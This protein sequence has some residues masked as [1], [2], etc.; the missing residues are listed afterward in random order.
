MEETDDQEIVVTATRLNNDSGDTSGR[1]F[2]Y[3]EPIIFPVE[4]GVASVLRTD[5]EEAIT[6]RRT[7]TIETKDG[8]VKISVD[9]TNMSDAQVG[10]TVKLLQEHARSP[11]AKAAFEVIARADA[12]RPGGLTITFRYDDKFSLYN[13]DT[14]SFNL[15]SFPSDQ[16]GQASG[17]RNASGNYE[18]HLSINSNLARS[19]QDFSFTAAHELF[20]VARDFGGMAGQFDDEELAADS[21]ANKVLD[22][23]FRNNGGFVNDTQ[24]YLHQIIDTG[25]AGADQIAGTTGRDHL[26]GGGGDD[27]VSGGAGVDGITGGAGNDRLDGED[28]DDWVEG[29]G[30]RDILVGGGGADMLIGGMDADLYVSAAGASQDVIA[31]AGGVDRLDLSWLGSDVASYFRE[32][33]DL[34]IQYGE[35]EVRVRGQYG[36]AGHVEQFTFA[37]GTYAA[38][39]IE[40]IIDGG[41][42]PYAGYAPPVV[43]DLDGDGIE[44]VSLDRS[45]ARF[46]INGD[47]EEERLGWVGRD[48][49]IL[50]LDR[51]GDGRI[52]RFD[53]I[54][55][56]GDFLGAGTDFEGLYGFDSDGD[57]FLTGA[58]TRFGEFQVWIDGNGNGRSERGE[59]FRLDELGIVSLNLEALKRAPLDPADRSNQIIGESWF[60]RTDGSRGALGDV[61]LV[62][63]DHFVGSGAASR[64]GGAEYLGAESL[65]SF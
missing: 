53:E 2:L 63:A 50:V 22:D 45:K 36:T 17:G 65:S 44:L 48:D 14:D 15:R 7:V 23:I 39:H 61:A 62:V 29:G 47:G 13:P 43:L 20:H 54:S 11:E 10:A 59:L 40:R 38:S 8:P 4:G 19:I 1:T 49:G 28:G 51:D 26:H 55:F 34:V 42:D 41:Y 6:N 3:V 52:S 27:I 32:G 16:L 31:E 25:S 56:T 12:Q 64:M 30:G 57:G 35:T 37:D 46:D 60:E 18:I 21:F 5:L 58:D 33:Q 24:D 9:K